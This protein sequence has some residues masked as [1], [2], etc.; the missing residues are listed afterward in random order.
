MASEKEKIARKLFEENHVLEELGNVNEN[1][2]CNDNESVS[3]ADEEEEEEERDDP[4]YEPYVHVLNFY[5][6]LWVSYLY[7]CVCSVHFVYL[8]LQI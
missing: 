4:D 8:L 3:K 5:T 7:L 6:R 1:E 2:S